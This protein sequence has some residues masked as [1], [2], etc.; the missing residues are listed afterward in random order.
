MWAF[1]ECEPKILLFKNVTNAAEI[2]ERIMKANFPCAAINPRYVRILILH[3]K[4]C[5]NTEFITV[6]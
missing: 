5:V 3:C 4:C 6:R 2:R 1:K